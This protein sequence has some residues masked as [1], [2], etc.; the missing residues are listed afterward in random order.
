[1]RTPKYKAFYKPHNYIYHVTDLNFEGPDYTLREVKL[2]NGIWVRSDKL[3]DTILLEQTPFTDKNGEEIFSAEE[4]GFKNIEAETIFGGNTKEEAAQIFKNILEGNGTYEQN[5]VVLANAAKALQ[6]TGKYKNY[7]TSLAAAKDSL[8]S[9]K[10]LDCLS[11]LII[12]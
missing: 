1:M 8:E 2:S 10:A 7:E 12:K 3:D 11:K 9:G 5:A 4:L 6:N